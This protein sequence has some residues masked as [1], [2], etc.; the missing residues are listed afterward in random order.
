MSLRD[1]CSSLEITAKEGLLLSE[2]AGT[3]TK[4]KR[5]LKSVS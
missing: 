4:E 3:E 2:W 5:I 1:N